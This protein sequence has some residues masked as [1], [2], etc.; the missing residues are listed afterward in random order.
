MQVCETLLSFIYPLK[1][2][3]TYIP[4]LP[5]SLTETL[6]AC[7]AFIVGMNTKDKNNVYKHIDLHDKIIIDKDSDSI[8]SN[9]NM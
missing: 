6:N 8:E 1:W 5:S 9:E 4:Y 3:C 7:G 2:R